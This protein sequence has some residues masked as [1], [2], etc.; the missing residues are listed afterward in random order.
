MNHSKTVFSERHTSGTKQKLKN[1]SSAKSDIFNI[2]NSD[3]DIQQQ[4][5]EIPSIITNQT[6][7]S[8]IKDIRKT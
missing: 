2:T 5:H 6:I 7:P 3:Y 1:A 4:I 8:H